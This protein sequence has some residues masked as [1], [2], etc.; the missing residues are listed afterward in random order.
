MEAINSGAPRLAD[1]RAP[2]AVSALNAAGAAPGAT[3]LQLHRI[4]PSSEPIAKD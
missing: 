1:S 4:Q 2:I 3:I